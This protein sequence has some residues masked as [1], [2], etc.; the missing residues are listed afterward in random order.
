[1]LFMT[2]IIGYG[3]VLTDIPAYKSETV[4]LGWQ[5]IFLRHIG[6]NWLV[7]IAVFFGISA[8][9]IRSGIRLWLFGF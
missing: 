8:R 4:Q 9:D 6:A 5:K 1:M 3:G 7:Y 2:I